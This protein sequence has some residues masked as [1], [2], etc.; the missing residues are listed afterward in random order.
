MNVSSPIVRFGNLGPPKEP[1]RSLTM[2]SPERAKQLTSLLES[3]TSSV[4][5]DPSGKK[6]GNEFSVT[7]GPKGNKYNV[8]FRQYG[9][10]TATR[11]DGVVKLET[12]TQAMGGTGFTYVNTEKP[13]QN[14]NTKHADVVAAAEALKQALE[15]AKT[16]G[17]GG[18]DA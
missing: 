13:D 16:G 10:F 1:V 12:F 7:M 4:K 6:G 8:R 2:L 14:V 17:G 9:H 5:A 3:L 11:A 18:F 15:D